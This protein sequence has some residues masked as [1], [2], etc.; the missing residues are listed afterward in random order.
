MDELQFKLEDF[1]PIYTKSDDDDIVNGNLKPLYESIIFKKEFDDSRALLNEPFPERG[2][3][4]KHQAFMSRFMSPYTPY[5]KMIAF[6]GLGSGKACLIMGVAEYAKYVNAGEL[7]SNKITVL[8]RNPTLRKGLI[9]ELACVCTAGRYEPPLRDEKTKD[10]LSKDTQR[11]RVE[12][13][14]KVEYDVMTFTMFVKEI[15]TKSNDQLKKE[16]SNRYFL[17]DEAHNIKL[18]PE[19]KKVRNEEDI[20]GL[21]LASRGISNYKEIHRLLHVVTGCKVLLLTATPMR[22]QPSEICNLLNLLLPLDKQLNKKEFKKIYFD[23]NIFK[24]S[25]KLNF[26]VLTRNLISYLRSSTTDIVVKN[27]GDIDVDRKFKFT[28]TVRLEMEDEQEEKYKEAYKKDSK[29]YKNMSLDDEVDDDADLDEDDPSKALWNNSRQAALF[30]SFDDDEKLNSLIKQDGVIYK[31]TEKLIKYLRED[32]DDFNSMLS[33][34]KKCSIKYWLVVRDIFKYPEQKFFIYSNIVKGSGALLLGSILQV[35]G[36]SH[37]PILKGKEGT[38]YCPE[39]KVNIED[40]RSEEDM[41]ISKNSNRMLVLTG[42]TLSANQLD[43]MVNDVF[44]TKE[45]RFGD[46]IRVII[47][48]HIVGEGVSFKHIRRMYVLTPAWNNGT[49]KQAIARAIRFKSHNDLPPDKRTVTI[50]RVASEPVLDAVSKAKLESIDMQMYKISEDKDIVIKQV[51]RLLKETAI[52]CALNRSRNLLPSDLPNTE[53]CDYMENCAYQCDLVDERY[54]HSNWVGDRIVDTYNLYYA[55]KEINIVKKALREAFQYKFAYDFEELYTRISEDIKGI[56]AIVLAR[57]LDS[58]I[59]NNEKVMN[60]YGLINYLREDRNMFFLVDDPLA[61][62]IFTSYYYSAH[63]V[64]ENSLG[65]FE[66]ILEYFQYDKVDKILETIIEY[67]TKPDIL[68]K[69]FNNLTVSIIQKIVEVFFIAKLKKTNVNVDLQ[70]FIVEKYEMYINNVSGNYI[71]TVD[72]NNPRILYKGKNNW[73]NL[74]EEETEKIKTM[75]EDKVNMLRK[76]DY[77]IYAIIADTYKGKDEHRNLKLVEI[78][79]KKSFG[80]TSCST[81][82]FNLNTLV[83]IYYKL[84]NKSILNGILPPILGNET[85]T[86]EKI[87]KLKLFDVLV[88]YIKKDIYVTKLRDILMDSDTTKLEDFVQGIKLPKEKK[89]L[90]NIISKAALDEDDYL[91][92]VKAAE[93]SREDLVKMFTG[94]EEKVFLKELEE[95]VIAEINTLSEEKIDYLGNILSG[96]SAPKICNALR[97]WFIEN[98]LYVFEEEGK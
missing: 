67:Q 33:Q 21:Q 86:L 16:Y 64:P 81:N 93:T 75:K 91:T 82:P 17:I 11:K 98:D 90:N 77:G 79:E 7:S 60:K 85:Y 12:R 34:L 13:N 47:G 26:K 36:M 20:L 51:E 30:T 5:D 10:L 54:Y 1:F 70:N 92:F 87:K 45:N 18:Q 19:K 31:P 59:T 83:G 58:M 65:T 43:I 39:K 73:V 48:S 14:I 15:Y 62:S 22:D 38:K 57:A 37:A 56:P 61:S 25:E 40:E 29:K 74:S 78:N 2:E 44:N 80:G 97:E 35:F 8:T 42:S 52:D 27:E 76:N 41:P 71:L 4:L 94:K 69:I 46:Y 66:E 32:G 89:K 28:K 49:T 6:H 63:P 68:T 88:E 23:G 55:E 3:Q 50:L 53:E 9:N 24:D 96:K 84:L 72:Q 95:E